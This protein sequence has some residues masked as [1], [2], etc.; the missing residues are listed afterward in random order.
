[1][2]IIQKFS[3]FYTDLASMKIDDLC[4]IYEKNVVFIDPIDTHH[5]IDAVKSYFSR[6]LQNTE[7]CQFTIH[8]IDKIVEKSVVIKWTMTYSTKRLNG[9][10][11]VNVEG[12]TWLDLAEDKIILHRDYFDLGQMI[13]ENV[14]LLGFFIKKVKG[15]LG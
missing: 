12:I 1:M 14:P 7:N 6:L 5:G 10:N 15:Q 11:P 8:S 4:S 13:Y 3:T 9:G 2:D